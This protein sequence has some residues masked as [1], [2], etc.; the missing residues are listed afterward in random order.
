ML[1]HCAYIV[2]FAPSMLRRRLA[3][4]KPLAWRTE[5]SVASVRISTSRAW[6]AG[7]T[8]NTFINTITPTS[9]E[10]IMRFTE[11]AGLHPLQQQGRELVG[12]VD[13]RSCPHASS[14]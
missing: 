12:H 13:I 2:T 7:S 9:P 14:S 3:D 6:F 4:M 5:T 10:R 8:V 11:L 1:C